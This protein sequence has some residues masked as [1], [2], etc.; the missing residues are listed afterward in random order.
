MRRVIVV[1][2]FFFFQ[3]EDGIRDATVT[4]VQTCALPIC[5]PVGREQEEDHEGPDDAVADQQGGGA[6]RPGRADH[7]VL[8]RMPRRM[9]N[10]DTA[11][12]GNM[13]SETAA[14]SGTSPEAMPSSKA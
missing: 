6:A 13:N 10:A 9:K 2:G 3:A 7:D 12:M 1:S 5:H 8:R 4:G 11:R 14:P